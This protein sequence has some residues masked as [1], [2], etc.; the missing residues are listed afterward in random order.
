MVDQHLGYSLLTLSLTLQ[1]Y[2][3]GKFNKQLMYKDGTLQLKYVGGDD[4]H[5]KKYN[6]TTIMYFICDHNPGPNYVPRYL[7][8]DFDCT[9]MF[10]WRTHLACMPFKPG[11][12]S[13]DDDDG[14]SYDLTQLTRTDR[15][16]EVQ[17]A[18][19][20]KFVLN[21]CTVVVHG[22]GRRWRNHVCKRGCYIQRHTCKACL[23]MDIA[24]SMLES[25]TSVFT[26]CCVA[27][28]TCPPNAASC[29]INTTDATQ[30]KW[31]DIL[32]WI[33]ESSQPPPPRLV[34]GITF[35]LCTI[36]F[37]YNQCWCENLPLMFLPRC[38]LQICKS[39]A[40]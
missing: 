10:E 33:K 23:S 35:L 6:R 32:R 18:A 1:C 3:P 15:N 30:T 12:C 9:Y 24:E 39:G 21:V 34:V 40:A 22:E 13:I 2:F 11:Q 26:L 5:N 38:Y 4:C 20:L 28:V 27:G 16:Y 17:N 29:L 8:E 37:L 25:F 14:N 31:V 19:H 7:K 36:I